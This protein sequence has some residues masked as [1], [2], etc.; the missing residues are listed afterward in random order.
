V[1]QPAL[2]I[3]MALRVPLQ[4]APGTRKSVDCLHHLRSKHSGR[5]QK[6]QKTVRGM[7]NSKKDGRHAPHHPVSDSLVPHP[8]TS[9]WPF[10]RS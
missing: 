1:D 7:R 2:V 5:D 8:T 3:T 6:V 10:N 4:D 9:P